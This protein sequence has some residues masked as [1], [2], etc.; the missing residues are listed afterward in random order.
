[1]GG[2]PR[3]QPQELGVFVLRTCCSS[4]TPRS[5]PRFSS[6]FCVAAMGKSRRTTDPA[7]APCEDHGLEHCYISCAKGMKKPA[8]HSQAGS[9]FIAV[10][11]ELVTRPQ[12]DQIGVC[13]NH[14][15]ALIDI[16]VN[17]AVSGL[18]ANLLPS[19]GRS[20]MLATGRERPTTVVLERPV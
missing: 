20:K 15:F 3:R 13:C 2:L 11:A 18:R 6:L 8:G 17:P 10:L 4:S 14:T 7:V 16:T 5:A 19:L 9:R 1:M 12:A